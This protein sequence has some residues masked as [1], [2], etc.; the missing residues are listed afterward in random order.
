MLPHCIVLEAVEKGL[1]IISVT[2]H[3]SA[4]NVAVTVALGNRFGVWVIPGMEIETREEVHLLCFFPS[5]KE[6][7]GFA[8]FISEHLQRLSLDE[9]LWGQEWVID[10]EGEIKEKKDYLL[11]HTLN[12]SL[13]DV[14][15]NVYSGGGV[16]IPSHVD[17]TAYSIIHVLGFI[18]PQLPIQAVEVSRRTSTQEAI[19]TLNLEGY[20]ILRFSDAHSLTDVGSAYST[21][22]M[23]ATRW[24]EFKMALEGKKGRRVTS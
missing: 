16:V 5:L 19:A 3:N 17:R 21:L 23:E 14:C 9:N 2:D 15:K 6:L 20:A 7:N 1:D 18:P 12:L 8:G 11:T 4:E 10:V 24:E 13:E 22:Y